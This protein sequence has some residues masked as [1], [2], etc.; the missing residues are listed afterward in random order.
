[1]LDASC[2]EGHVTDIHVGIVLIENFFL[3]SVYINYPFNG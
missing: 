1:M 3:N 2:L